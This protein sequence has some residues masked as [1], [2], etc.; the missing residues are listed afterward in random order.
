[1]NT[2]G[3]CGIGNESTY[4]Q[5]FSLVKYIVKEYGEDKLQKI[6]SSLSNPFTYSIDKAIKDVLGISSEEVY[7]NWKKEISEIFSEQI[8]HHNNTENYKLLE[9]EGTTNIHPI[10]NPDGNSFLFLSNK[11]NDYFGQTDLFLYS[12]NDSESKKIKGGIKSAPTWVNEN[13]IIYSKKSKPNEN[14]SK[15]FDLYSYNLEEEEE[16]RL[17]IGLRLFSPVFDVMKNKVYAVN[18]YDGT[19]NI[20]SVDNSEDQLS[21]KKITNFTNGL[22]IFSISL[23]DSLILFDG[24]ENHERNIYYFNLNDETSGLYKANKWDERDPVSKNGSMITSNDRFGIFNI[25]LSNNEIG[26]YLSNVTGGAFMPDISKNGDII[27]SVY[28]DGGY[29]V[30]LL[31]DNGVLSDTNIGINIKARRSDFI[32]LNDDIT[33]EYYFRPTSKLINSGLDLKTDD[34]EDRM[35][36][37]FIMPRIM[38]DYDTFKPGFYIFDNDLLGKMS[39]LG[40]VSFNNRKDTDIFLLFEH[41]K[42]ALSY[43]FNFYFVTRN[44]SRTHPYINSLG[45]EIPSIKFDI[46]YTYHLFSADL[47]SRFIFKDHKFWI[48]YTYSKYRQFYNISKEQN[49]ENFYDFTVGD[50]AHDYYS[51][52]SI[53]LDYEFDGRKKYY[54]NNMI[55]R[56]GFVV[57]SSLAYEKNN[58][59]EEFRVNENLGSISEYL[60]SHNSFRY[61]FDFSKH[62]TLFKLS[63]KNNYYVSMTNNLKFMGLSNKNVD[64]FLY[65][66]GGGLTGLK[67]FTYYEPSLQGTKLFTFTNSISFP[68]FIEKA[69]KSMFIYLNSL[70]LGLVHQMGRASEGKIIVYSGY[71][72]IPEGIEIDSNTENYILGINSQVDFPLCH[73]SGIDA[74]DINGCIPDILESYIYPDI[75]SSYNGWNNEVMLNDNNISIRDLKNRYDKLKQSIGLEIKLYGFSFYS[76][77]TALTYECH[78]PI[79]DSWNSET[80]HYLKVL[81]DFN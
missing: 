41:N 68:L 47:G 15:F 11:L 55:P 69:H 49:T 71:Y 79:S 38:Y 36:G 1:M 18:T 3:K 5:G 63:D 17:T 25:Y 40:G 24:V 9:I 59:F 39:I 66:F 37:P 74:L 12:M 80:R 42:F 78:I 62:W 57:K 58:I 67:G 75:Y 51:G 19:C 53:T 54:L 7:E 20:V 65:F 72:E 31:N 28:Q 56:N 64:D 45:Q 10:W 2:F 61:Q 44:L 81:F 73:G 48:K 13:L 32:Q 34:Y 26:N 6:T 77:P 29:K 22:Q 33:T 76:Y 60:A 8:I 14:G 70:S 4:N 43:F 27:F 16:K 23:K 52:H 35:T 46:D 50:G 30:A 21:Y